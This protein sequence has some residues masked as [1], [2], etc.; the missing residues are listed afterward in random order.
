[1][2]Y[3]RLASILILDLRAAVRRLMLP[4]LAVLAG[5]VT[6]AGATVYCVGNV[7]ELKSV[8]AAVSSNGY[9]DF[10][11]RIR[12]GYYLLGP[13][14]GHDYALRLQHYFRPGYQQ[15]GNF[16]ISGAW[17]VDCSAQTSSSTLLDGQGQ[18]GILQLTVK[19]YSNPSLD[20]GDPSM[21]TVDR[22]QFAHGVVAYD[23][24]LSRPGCL[25]LGFLNY[26]PN[27]SI[28]LER[29][30]FDAC[31]NA[32]VAMNA[33]GTLTLRNSVFVANR[34]QRRSTAHLAADGGVRIYNNTFR[35]NELLG[36]DQYRGTLT[37][38]S[39]ATSYVFNNIFADN[40]GSPDLGTVL[41]LVIVRNN[42]LLTVEGNTYLQDNTSVTPGFASQYVYHL[43]SHSPLRDFGI[44]PPY[45]GAG[46]HDFA[47]NARVQGAAI[48]PGAFELAPLPPPA[49]TAIFGNGFE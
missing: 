27:L 40:I 21:L 41:G 45:P 18:T 12:H 29:L 32:A 49:S 16:R 3:F 26:K 22:L 42:R 11:I 19:Y 7:A 39:G 1:M 38:T 35:Y 10:D 33:G 9:S 15:S 30:R 24:L 14:V 43:A 8:V 6:D 13:E 20:P 17:N 47:G 44:T 23:P 34:G 4:A 48:E 5:S 46:S 36:S 28:H 31:E 2:T 25:H 37:L